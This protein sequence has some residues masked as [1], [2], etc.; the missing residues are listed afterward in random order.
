MSDRLYK[1]YMAEV[2]DHAA[3]RQKYFDEASKA[4]DAGDGKK[5]KELSTKGKEEGK[6]ME[7]AILK[8]GH[9]IYEGKW[10]VGFRKTDD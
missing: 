9:L 4:H 1:K 5:A 10:V 2:D 6:L 8:A 3:Q 7:A